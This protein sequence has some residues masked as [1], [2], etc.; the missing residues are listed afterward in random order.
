MLGL[1]K[2]PEWKPRGA[3]GHRAYAIGDVHGRLDLLDALLETI[4]RDDRERAPRQTVLVMLGDLI[5]RGP[6]SAEV[7]ERLR[8]F[9]RPRTRPV[10]LSGNHEEILLRLIGGEERLLA[11]WLRFG[12]GECLAS[13]GA[14]PR[15]IAAMAPD[16]AIAAIRAA[17]PDA[18]V[19]FLRGFSDTFRFGDYLFVHAGIRPGLPLHQQTQADLRWIRSPF[20]EDARDHDFMVVHGHTIV[21]TVEQRPNRIALDTGAYRSGVLTALGVEGDDRWLLE[22]RA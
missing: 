21:E 2:T 8:T 6:S 3:R 17:I 10:F 14:D 16:E 13:Y 18:H 12:G 4:D 5:D 22:A 9:E 20:L 15:R 11:G 7:V 19:A 1:L